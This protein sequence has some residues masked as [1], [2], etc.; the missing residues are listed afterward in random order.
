MPLFI[1]LALLIAFPAR[2]LEIEV[3]GVAGKLL[4][5]AKAEV[6]AGET[7]GAFTARVLGAST[8]DFDGDEGGVRKIE[9][10]GGEL[11][12][13]S[14]SEMNAYGWCYE[15]D[16]ALSDLLAGD[17]PLTPEHGRLKWFFAYA[18]YDSGK[19]TGFCLPADHRPIDGG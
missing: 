9:G 19:W 12:L 8:L 17:H 15:V 18:S 14:D 6:K 7:V 11:E 16:G 2:A 5:A 3:H 4:H 13:L 1:L 10:L